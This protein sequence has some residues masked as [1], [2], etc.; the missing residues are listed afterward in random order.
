MAIAKHRPEFKVKQGGF[1]KV[2]LQ[3]SWI[4][5]EVKNRNQAIFSPPDF[6]PITQGLYS[7]SYKVHPVRNNLWVSIL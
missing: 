6:Y 3:K 7:P 5:A 1:Y 4:K 2:T